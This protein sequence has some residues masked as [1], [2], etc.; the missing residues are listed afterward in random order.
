M[1]TR[2]VRNRLKAEGDGR[3]SLIAAAMVIRAPCS[4]HSSC[5]SA[6]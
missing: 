2:S 3:H 4:I 5:M 1:I 6:L